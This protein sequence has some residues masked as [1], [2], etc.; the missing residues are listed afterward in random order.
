VRVNGSHTNI[1]K[2]FS[3]HPWHPRKESDCAFVKDGHDV[4]GAEIKL[5]EMMS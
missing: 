1:Y 2:G 5:D 3:E 4:S